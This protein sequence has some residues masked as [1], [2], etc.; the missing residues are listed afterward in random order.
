MVFHVCM[1]FVGGCGPHISTEEEV[2]QE[3]LRK[4]LQ[5][6]YETNAFNFDSVLENIKN[7][8]STK[9]IYKSRERTESF[10]V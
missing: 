7:I 2:K 3:T 6:M 4:E 9:K 5:E 8:S 10:V 1:N